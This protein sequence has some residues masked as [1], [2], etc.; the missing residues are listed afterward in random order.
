MENGCPVLPKKIKVS[1]QAQVNEDLRDKAQRIAQLL[2]KIDARR[3]KAFLS[4]VEHLIETGDPMTAW[5]IES[6]EKGLIDPPQ[7]KNQDKPDSG[8]YYSF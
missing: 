2:M 1:E 8:D 6:T 7:E 3:A 4:N 5:F